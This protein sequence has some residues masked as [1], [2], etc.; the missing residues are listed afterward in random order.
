MNPLSPI[1]YYRRHLRSTLLLLSLIALITFGVCVMVRLPD[2]IPE[3]WYNAGL[4]LTRVSLVSAAG[5]S[6]DPGVVAQIRT[7]PD[8]AQV[9]EEKGLPMELPALGGEYH[10]FGLTKADMQVLMDTCGLRLKEGRLPRPRTSEMLLSEEVANAMGIGIGGQIDRS[11]GEDWSGDNYY[12]AIPVPLRLVGILEGDPAAVDVP[13]SPGPSIR[14]GFVSYEYVNNHELF[15]PPW[16]HGLVVIAREGR[17]AKVDDFLETEIAS[18]RT[19]VR[20]HRQLAERSARHSQTFHLI[21]G[22]VDFLVTVVMALVVGMIYQIARTKRL[23]EFGVLNAVGHSRQRLMRRVTLET[24]GVAVLGWIVGLMFAWLLFALLRGYF[25]APKGMDLSLA[26]LTPIWFALPIPLAAVA[27]VSLSSMRTFTRLD[28]VAIIERGKLSLEASDQRQ[29]AQRSSA[30]P[31]SAWT[32]YVRHRRRGLTLTVTMGLVILGVSFPAFLFA[33]MVDAMTPF[34]EPLRQVGIVIPR[35]GVAV[36]PGLAAQI[37]AHPD[38]ARVI[39]AI[40]LPLRAEVPPRFGWPISIFGV[41]EDDMQTLMRLYGVEVKEGHLP[42]P[43]T[44]E[45]VISE[46]M[47]LNRSLGVGDRIGQLVDERDQQIPTEMVIVGIVRQPQ[48]GS[49]ERGSP[50]LRSGQVGKAPASSQGAQ[51]NDVWLGFASYEYLSSHELYASWPVNLLVVPAEGRKAELDTWLQANADSDQTEVYT[52]EWM[53]D[54]FRMMTLIVA[55]LFGVVE[56]VI[57]VVAAI[58]LAGLSYTF[59]SQRREE[60]GTLHALGHSRRWLTLR[61]VRET[62]TVVAVAWLMGAAVCMAGLA[63]IHVGLYVPKGLTV[64]FFNPTPWLFTLPIPLAVVAV[65]GGLVACMLSRL[66][67]VSV[68]E[69]RS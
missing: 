55:A 41:S 34:A 44:N 32:F 10:L 17:K 36:D 22:V 66:D 65:S 57:A 5:P 45:I 68:I 2:S 14:L 8:V 20:T 16:A 24:T 39:P 3:N 30:S 23:A 15:T 53:R 64:N 9:I 42:R 35:M 49:L 48:D 58:A 6:L 56:S 25:Y 59:F 61:T 4:Y 51:A 29:T 46:G 67:P 50:R 37:R 26:N 69:R 28:P 18:I 12:Q 40:E 38:V 21:L 33:P 54:N 13:S 52:F 7:H 1:T 31:L 47:A 19:Q 27:F 63:Y 11:I 62:V 60:F 43:R